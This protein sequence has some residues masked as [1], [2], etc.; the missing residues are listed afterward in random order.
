[1]STL[2]P[3]G[4]KRALKDTANDLHVEVIDTAGA[5]SSSNMAK[6][7]PPDPSV[8]QAAIE[9]ASGGLS[10]ERPLYKKRLI[11]YKGDAPTLL[12]QDLKNNM[13]EAQLDLLQARQQEVFDNTP[14]TTQDKVH[15]ALGGKPFFK[16]RKILPP[17][18]AFVED[19]GSKPD[20]VRQNPFARLRNKP[21][22]KATKA[23][24]ESHARSE[25]AEDILLMA[26]L[27]QAK[28]HQRPYSE[29]RALEGK[30]V[31][32]HLRVSSTQSA[33]S[34]HVLGHEWLCLR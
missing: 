15:E 31:A 16:R 5:A 20:R 12:L 10:R 19:Q 25:S 24:G 6:H 22:D 17:V 27:K 30:T 34:T 14:G 9:A 32:L 29:R 13:P 2:P 26:T 21:S 33:C 8:V 7:C 11:D 4:L 28:E 1:M 3:A 23:Q 18:P